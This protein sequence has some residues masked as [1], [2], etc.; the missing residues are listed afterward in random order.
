MDELT[1]R[2]DDSERVA[3]DDATGMMFEVA[4]AVT[5]GYGVVVVRAWPAILGFG[6]FGVQTAHGNS[7]TRRSPTGLASGCAWDVIFNSI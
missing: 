4:V 7:P 5:I 3:N 6:N 2:H 1:H